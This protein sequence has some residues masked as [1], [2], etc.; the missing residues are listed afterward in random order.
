LTIL[1]GVEICTH[2]LK[3]EFYLVM[4]LW[5]LWHGYLEM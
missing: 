1:F 3:F 4:Y 2:M 5:W